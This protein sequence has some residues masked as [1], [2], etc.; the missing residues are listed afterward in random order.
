MCRVGVV[1][2]SGVAAQGTLNVTP[3]IEGNKYTR[4]IAYTFLAAR[5]NCVLKFHSEKVLIL[6]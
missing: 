3:G 1:T 5:Y 2:Q 4:C 6:S